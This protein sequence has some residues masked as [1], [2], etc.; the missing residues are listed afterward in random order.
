MQAYSDSK[1]FVTALA[2]VVAR[3]WPD[4]LSNAVDPG[5]V[6]T[7]M[8]RPGAPDDLDL[9]HATQAWL[10]VS[11][12]PDAMGSGRYWHHQSRQ[13]PVSRSEEHT[14]ELQSP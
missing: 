3:L 13:A 4:V 9:G 1:L 12:E 10:A 14:S 2:S 6:P 5:W 11:R 7:R 8:G